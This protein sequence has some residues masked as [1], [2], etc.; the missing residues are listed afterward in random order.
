MKSKNYMMESDVK[1]DSQQDT[2]LLHQ[3]TVDARS[4]LLSH[5]WCPPLDQLWLT[6]GIGGVIGVF[7]AKLSKPIDGD[8]TSLWIVVGDLPSAYL[9][10]DFDAEPK[11][12]L[13]TYCGLMEE[14]VQSVKKGEPLAKVYPVHTK[15]TVDMANDLSN[16]VEYLRQEV[17]PLIG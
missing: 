2:M 12:V 13:L 16:R 6:Y 14:W 7:L 3:M 15:P 17:V 9:A 8:V 10:M 1:G 5:T 4:F 11:E